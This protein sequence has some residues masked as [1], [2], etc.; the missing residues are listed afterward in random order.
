MVISDVEEIAEKIESMKIRGA[1]KIAR[2]GA[3]G[4]KLTVEKSKAETN[5][6][7][8]DEL[9]EASETLL[10][11]RPTAVSLANSLR[12]VLSKA[13]EISE[14]E[15]LSSLK[16]K[17]ISRAN[18]FIELS[19]KA[20]ERIGEIGARRISDGDTIMTHCHSTNAL[21]VIK[22]AFDQGKDIEVIACEARPRQQGFITIQD[23]TDHDIP[24][25]LIVDSAARYFMKKVDE[26]VV[27]A[28]S[29]A[30]NGAVVNKIGTSQIALS[31]YEARVPTFVAAES[32]KF[33]P[34]TL[35]GRL[36]EIEE[37]D[38]KEIV[39]PDRFPEVNIQNPAFDVTP[40]E[41]V[42]L[43]ITERGIIP[44]EAAYELL[45]EQFEL[46]LEESDYF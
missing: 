22:T 19:E 28:D 24:T 16:E 15:D 18:N 1:G 10:N 2:A 39:D 31:A 4:L 42:D 45:Q 12:F 3:R 35:V 30:A 11:T 20:K 13:E 40:A 41:Y 14:T 44:P 27:G 8:Q 21:S 37:R 5:S 6:E 9:N 38:P 32:Y 43:I 34:Q 23:L 36:V 29:I 33:H 26:V 25:S 46:G 17:T 7:L